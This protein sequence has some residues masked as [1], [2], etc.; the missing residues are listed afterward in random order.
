M[1]KKWNIGILGCGNIADIYILN[2]QKYFKNICIVACA[3]K[4][5]ENAKK[6]AIKYEIPKAVTVDEMLM[7]SE[8]EVILNLTVPNVHFDLNCKILQAGK[9]VYS[10]KPLALSLE[11]INIL[12]QISEKTGKRIA[13][14]PDTWLGES[15]QTCMQMI[16]ENRIG[17]IVSFT[18]NLMNH[19]VESWHPSPYAYYKEGGGP[20]LDMGPYY[21]TTLVALLGPV[22]EVKAYKNK[23]LDVREIYSNPYKGEKI[24]V[25]VDTNYA[26]LLKL[27]SGVIGNLNMSFDIWNSKLPMLEIYGTKGTISVPDPNWFNGEVKVVEEKKILKNVYAME[28]HERIYSLN[29]LD[30]W[31][32]YSKINPVYKTP[33]NN[34]RGLGLWDMLISIEKKQMHKN[35]IDL[36]AHVMEVLLKINLGENNIFDEKIYNQCNPLQPIFYQIQEEE[37]KSIWLDKEI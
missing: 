15:I 37:G 28:N 1:R 32:T 8:I 16:Q 7:D 3:A 4:H 34:M 25:E 17:R 9:H 18:A 29:H 24:D 20:V 22:A 23:G 14:A 35:N 27:Q 5:I 13:C 30:N 11:E 6:F 19:G 10:E 2:I 36:I 33:S 31:Y 12:K 26:A 21:I